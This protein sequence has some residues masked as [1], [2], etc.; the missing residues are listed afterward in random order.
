MSVFPWKKNSK[1]Q[2]SLNFLQSGPRKFTKKK[3]DFFGIG[4]N[5]AGS[6]SIYDPGNLLNL[7]FSGLAPIRRVLTLSTSSEMASL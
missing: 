5:P 6:D 4:P 7:I 2:S 3:S 1:S